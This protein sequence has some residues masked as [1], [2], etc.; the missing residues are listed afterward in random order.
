SPTLPLFHSRPIESV[1]FLRYNSLGLVSYSSNY[2]PN[3][4]RGVAGKQRLRGAPR[5]VAASCAADNAKCNAASDALNLLAR[6]ASRLSIT[7]RNIMKVKTLWLTVIALALFA[8]SALAQVG[9]IEGDVVKKGTN[10]PIV[11]AEVEIIRTDI[12]GNYPVKS[13]K[14]GHF[15]HAGVPFV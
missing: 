12:K 2:F 13:D 14:K 5:F 8:V 1:T 10:E 9:R 7:R 4:S 15:L 3:V 11:G 6:E